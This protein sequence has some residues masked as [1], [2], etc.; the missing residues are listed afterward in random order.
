MGKIGWSLKAAGIIALAAAVPA[1]A[2]DLPSVLAE[3]DQRFTCP[4]FLPDDAARRA[5]M[6]AFSRAIASV[7]PKRLTYRQAAYIHARMLERHH[8]TPAGGAMA[9]AAPASDIPT[10]PVAAAGN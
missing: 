7:G 1:G 6:L 2:A 3:I 8:C 5:D 9:S 10:R 4:E